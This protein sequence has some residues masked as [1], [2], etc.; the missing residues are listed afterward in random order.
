M[1][2]IA[3]TQNAIS[4]LSG[5]YEYIAK[6]SPRYAIV[7]IDRITNRTKQLADFPLSGVMVHEYQRIDIREVIEYSYRIIYM[8]ESQTVYILAVIHGAQLLGDTPPQ[9]D[10]ID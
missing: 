1:N 6:D 8:Y 3:W 10:K 4:D 5:I 7:V 9:K 2:K